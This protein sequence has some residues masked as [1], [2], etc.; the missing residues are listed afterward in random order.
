MR[1]SWVQ[2]IVV[3]FIGGFIGSRIARQG[4]Q[5]MLRDILLGIVGGVIGGWIFRQLGYA[6]VTGINFWSILVS[7]C[8]AA[9]VIWLY[10]KFGK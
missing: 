3:G 1:L 10:H 7:A 9:L 2:W 4:G 5:G 6:G 8:G